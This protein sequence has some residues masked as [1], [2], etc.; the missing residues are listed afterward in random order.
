MN[1]SQISKERRKILVVKFI[2]APAKKSESLNSSVRDE[3]KF[4]R[5]RFITSGQI[6]ETE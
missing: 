4:K 6:K 3:L 2:M 1:K 5:S